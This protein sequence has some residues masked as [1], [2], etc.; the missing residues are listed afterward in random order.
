MGAGPAALLR[1]PPGD[2]AGGQSLL[3]LSR[4]LAT[5]GQVLTLSS[6]SGTMDLV[7]IPRTA[8]AAGGVRA[9]LAHALAVVV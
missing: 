3:Q 2:A 9:R 7:F 1:F 6:P 5:C 4:D 8:A